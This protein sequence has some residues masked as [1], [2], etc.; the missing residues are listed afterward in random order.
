MGSYEILETIAEIAVTIVGFTGVVF[1]IGQYSNAGITS[2]QRMGIIHLLIP[3]SLSL[4]LAL[5]PLV[6]LFVIEESPKF[7]RSLNLL[8]GVIH[9]IGIIDATRR[10][11]RGQA[12][13]PVQLQ[14]VLV[15][16]AYLLILTN[17]VIAIGYLHSLAVAIYIGSICWLLFISVLQF[18][19][20]ILDNHKGDGDA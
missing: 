2:T 18:V 13:D 12:L 16:I 1:A 4:F 5:L 10:I 9:V 11:Y 7:W 14:I 3:A 8:I 19:L 6:L 20:L 15:V 17:F